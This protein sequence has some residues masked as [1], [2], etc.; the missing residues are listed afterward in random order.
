MS[1]PMGYMIPALG[2][3]WMASFLIGFIV[4]P[5]LRHLKD[6]RKMFA[7][8]RDQLHRLTVQ[9]PH[10]I[11][12]VHEVRDHVRTL[13]ERLQMQIAQLRHDGRE[14]SSAEQRAEVIQRAIPGSTRLLEEI[15]ELRGEFKTKIHSIEQKLDEL[16]KPAEPA[17]VKEEV[18][19]EENVETAAPVPFEVYREAL[20][21]LWD[22][23]VSLD[24]HCNAWRGRLV[25]P[26]PGR[27]ARA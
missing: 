7:E 20:L 17:P 9:M 11:E 26:R 19:V 5:C 18:Y 6:Q 2:L 27:K 25:L 21:R 13:E 23:Q 22:G 10:L 1:D 14:R 4:M 8:Q 15:C 12:F 3:V 24:E 16:S